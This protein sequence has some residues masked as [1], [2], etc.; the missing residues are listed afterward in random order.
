[1][2]PSAISLFSTYRVLFADPGPFN[3]HHTSLREP[4]PRMTS[5]RVLVLA[6][7]DTKLFD[8]LSVLMHT[9]LAFVFI[10]LSAI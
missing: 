3:N 2:L 1:M 6:S 7:A 8:V 10:V 5:T 9:Y 4:S